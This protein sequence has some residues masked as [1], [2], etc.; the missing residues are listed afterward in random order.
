[1]KRVLI[2]MLL[3]LGLASCGQENDVKVSAVHMPAV[4][5]AA[6]NN[7]TTVDL[8]PTHLLSITLDAQLSTGYGWY[9]DGEQTLLNLAGV[10]HVISD[11]IGGID[12]VTLHFTGQGSGNTQLN[13]VYK[14]PFEKESAALA[15]T[16]KKT[17]SVGVNVLGKYTGA[18]T[19]EPEYIALEVEAVDA[20]AATSYYYCNASTCPAIKNQKSCG[21]CWSFATVGVV[22]S[23]QKIK[24]GSYTSI[25]E[26]HLISCNTSGYSCANGGLQCFPWYYNKADKGGKIGTVYTSDYPYTATDTACKTS[27]THH[28]KLTGW[29][30]LTSGVGSTANMKTWLTTYGPLWVGVCADT[31]FQNYTSG[32]FKGSSCSSANHAVVI[33]GYNDTD[34]AWLMR[35]SW[36]ASWGESGYMRIKYGVNVIGTY[37]SYAAIP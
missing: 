28:D 18:Y 36:G 3:G 19:G 9:V 10:T 17:Y 16:E 32:V 5:L 34:G 22:E 26:Q 15:G 21:G 13:L 12:K 33:V 23:M 11:Q 29:K 7:N 2:V 25:S 4:A 27:V 14:R 8:A 20:A 1:M 30:Q 35:N 24:N 37:A 31:A 6:A